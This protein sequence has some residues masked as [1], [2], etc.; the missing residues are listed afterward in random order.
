MKK[1]VGED[2]EGKNVFNKDRAKRPLGPVPKEGKKSKEG[3]SQLT[4][5]FHAGRKQNLCLSVNPEIPRLDFR[6]LQTPE[7]AAPQ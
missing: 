1:Q 6:L 4:Y 5:E 2:G 7:R 3:T